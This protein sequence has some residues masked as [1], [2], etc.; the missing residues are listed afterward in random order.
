MTLQF[1]TRPV[2]TSEDTLPPLRCPGQFPMVPGNLLNV[3]KITGARVLIA[4][5][6]ATLAQHRIHLGEHPRHSNNLY[7]DG[8]YVHPSIVDN[9]WFFRRNSL[10]DAAVAMRFQAQSRGN[11][12]FG[13]EPVVRNVVRS[14]IVVE[15]SNRKRTDQLARDVLAAHGARN[16]LTCTQQT[17]QALTSL[18]IAP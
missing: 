18:S 13:L 16:R 10:P 15:F 17:T 5:L 11:R 9:L 3:G 12:A 7:R 6:V 2:R 14:A 8:R 4:V 1:T